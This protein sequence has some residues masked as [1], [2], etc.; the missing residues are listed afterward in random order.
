M[1]NTRYI[2]LYYRCVSTDMGTDAAGTV[3][4]DTIWEL[5][6]SKR[7]DKRVA[8]ISLIGATLVAVVVAP[9]IG[10][11]A[12]LANSPF[13][14]KALNTDGSGKFAIKPFAKKSGEITDPPVTTPAPDP[15]TTQ[16]PDPMANLVT[17]TID[18]SL[19]SC[20]A[21]GTSGFKLPVAAFDPGDSAKTPLAAKAK[22]DWGDG[23]PVTDLTTGVNG[24]IY[25]TGR[26]TL[27][28][29]GKLGGFDQLPAGSNNCVAS[30]DHFGENTGI[31]T[32]SR[33][34]SEAPATLTAVAAPPTSLKNASFMFASSSFNGDTASWNLPNLEN[35][36]SMFANA[37]KFNGDLKNFNPQSLQDAEQMFSRATAFTGIGL[38]N[39]RTPKLTKASAMFQV[40]P[41]FNPDLSKWDVHSVSDFGSMFSSATKFNSDLSQWNVSSGKI[42]TSMF[43]GTKAFNSELN[44]WNMSNATD[45]RQIFYQATAFNRD[46]NRWDTRNVAILDNMFYGATVFNGDVSDWDTSNVTTMRSVFGSTPVFNRDIS[47]WNVAKVAD[48][49]GMFSSSKAFNQ[50]LSAWNTASATNM[51][52][53]F[54]NAS[55]FKQNISG[56]NVTKVTSY[57]AFYANSGLLSTSS[58]VP[59]KFRNSTGSTF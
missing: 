21:T 24:H 41:N 36:T 26:Y 47:R 44:D 45:F 19:P 1:L 27:S 38:E 50:D 15:T 43:S 11:A 8:R 12:G 23:S 48:F 33:F 13:A 59:S 57:S 18:T 37:S 42:F 39:W 30:I 25:K 55:G 5:V 16:A 9:M 3:A 49:S 22:L 6:L 46:L 34:L 35:G 31:V 28:I 52:Q 51:L 14:I 53:M 20:I 54:Y 7:N 32:L 56:W 10:S 40:L 29:D 58:F 4:L 2:L 17:M